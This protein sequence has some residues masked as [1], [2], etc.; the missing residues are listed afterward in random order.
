GHNQRHGSAADADV[1]RPVVVGFFLQYRKFLL[2]GSGETEDRGVG[3]SGRGS[4]ERHESLVVG[5]VGGRVVL[6]YWNQKHANPVGGPA[7]VVAVGGVQAVPHGVDAGLHGIS[8]AVLGLGRKTH[9]A[10]ERPVRDR[11][12]ADRLSSR[13]RT[14][15]QRSR[16]P[17]F[18]P[19]FA[20]GGDLDTGG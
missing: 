6:F 1:D 10:E 7:H 12:Q 8:A 14:G 3:V 11:R 20:A 5:Q 19:R 15:R 17:K 2:A 16:K 13:N 18:A 9:D 4:A